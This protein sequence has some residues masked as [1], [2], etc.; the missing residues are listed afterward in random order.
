VYSLNAPVPAEISRLARGL[1]SN[2]FDA[3]PRDRHTLV[4]KRLGGGEP[5][6]LAS[7]VRSRIVGTEPFSARITGVETFENPATG[8]APVAYLRVESPGIE[9][10]HRRLCERFDP[11]EGIE[12]DDYVPHVTIARGG[13]AGRLAGQ[14]ITREWTVDSLVVWSTEYREPAERIALPVQRA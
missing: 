13:D 11:A 8:R 9:H 4:V 1:A 3:T 10:L 5:R 6:S 14:E 12:A 2:C 7:E